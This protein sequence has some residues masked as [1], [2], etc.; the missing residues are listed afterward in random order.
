[1]EVVQVEKVLAKVASVTRIVR[2]KVSNPPL[3]P[4]PITPILA[5]TPNITKPHLQNAYILISRFMGNLNRVEVR[6]VVY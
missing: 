5:K 2:N 6:A 3:N 4:A 1:M